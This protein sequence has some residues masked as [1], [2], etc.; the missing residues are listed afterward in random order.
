MNYFLKN[1]K[2]YV[3]GSGWLFLGFYRGTQE[4][5]FKYKNKLI[6]YEKNKIPRKPIFF[7]N[8]CFINGILGSF[9]YI[10][11]IFIYKIIPKEL[12]RL[13]VCIRNIEHEKNSRY[14]NELL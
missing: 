12:Y 4:Y 6:E 5:N 3:F 14:Y 13:E 10:F 9:I 8:E 2:L 1:T 7:Y 11:P